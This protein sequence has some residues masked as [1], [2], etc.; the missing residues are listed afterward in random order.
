[1]QFSTLLVLLAAAPATMAWQL[2]IYQG[3]KT[4]DNRNANRVLRGG[5]AQDGC[6]TLGRD[7]P[8]VGC[9]H[10]ARDG[11]PGQ[12][13]RGNLRAG[14]V[15]VGTG[16]RCWFYSGPDCTGDRAFR[17]GVNDCTDASGSEVRSFQCRNA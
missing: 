16:E 17:S 14:S 6:Y 1:M 4:C 13:C 3:T 7:L 10:Y 2:I 9:T 8:G 11:A 5:N 12:A 15:R